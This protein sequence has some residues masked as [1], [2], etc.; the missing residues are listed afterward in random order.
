MQDKFNSKGIFLSFAAAIISGFA[1]FMNKFGVDLWQNSSIYTSAKNLTAALFLVCAFLLFKKIPELSGLT[2]KTW[3]K[4]ITIGIIGGSVPFL[5]FFR[6]LLLIPA[7]EAAFIQ[8]TM[9]IWV[10][11]FSY[12]LLK[13]KL[14]KIQLA[15]LAILSA[16]I[17]FL[18]APAK[19]EFGT[20]AILVFAATLL[21]AAENMIAKT[22]LKEISSVTAALA[23]MFFGAL[24][25]LS[26]LFLTGEMSGL[27]ESSFNQWKWA[28]ITG[29]VL[30]AYV[31]CWYGALKYAPASVV[32]SILVLA[33]PITA[34][35][36]NLYSKGVFPTNIM[37]PIFI[38]SIGAILISGIFN[39]LKVHGLHAQIDPAK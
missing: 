1:V 39:N 23:R 29:A 28:F 31:W 4:L 16:G 3:M 15:A 21:W 5:L 11:I 6:G 20:G 13:E 10:A 36:E 33:A 14:G 34:I 8:K 2:K 30:F 35:I 18:G 38:I 17:Y 12:A 19:W 22:V 7:T 27:I 25:L 37:L 26:Y 24:A 32:S 9:F